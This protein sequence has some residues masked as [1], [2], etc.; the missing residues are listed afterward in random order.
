MPLWVA[1]YEQMQAREHLRL[2]TLWLPEPGSPLADDLHD[3]EGTSMTGTRRIDV[4][5]GR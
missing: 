2:L 5:V 4:R 3:L 1:R